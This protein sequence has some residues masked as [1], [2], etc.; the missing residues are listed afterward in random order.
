MV[1]S[2]DCQICTPGANR[3][4][5]TDELLGAEL[6]AELDPHLSHHTRVRTTK[7]LLQRGCTSKRN[8]RGILT[9]EANREHRRDSS[10][11]SPAA[12]S[13]ASFL[14]KLSTLVFPSLS[15]LSLRAALAF[16]AGDNTLP[17]SA[18]SSLTFFLTGVVAFAFFLMS[19]S[20]GLSSSSEDNSMTSEKVRAMALA[21]LLS[22]LPSFFTLGLADPVERELEVD[23]AEEAEMDFFI[24]ADEAEEEEGPGVPSS[25]LEGAGFLGGDEASCLANMLLSVPFFLAR[26]CIPRVNG[27]AQAGRK[28]TAVVDAPG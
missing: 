25:S 7:R 5:W 28:Q 17:A 8:E 22:E 1:H 16:A 23:C 26:G 20:S 14:K 24:D 21:L 9:T 13:Y 10:S 18:E 27:L 19:S 3:P 6:L 11:T 4:A 12:P 2:L 15:A